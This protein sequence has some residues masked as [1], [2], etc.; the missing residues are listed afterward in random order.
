MERGIAIGMIFII[1]LFLI[2]L[3]ALTLFLI[4]AEGGLSEMM[5]GLFEIVS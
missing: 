4:T 2:I 1:L 3:G 5:G